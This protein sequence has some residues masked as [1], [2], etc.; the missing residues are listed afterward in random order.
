MIHPEEAE[1][2][3]HMQPRKAQCSLERDHSGAGYTW[4]SRPRLL[5][6]SQSRNHW[7]GAKV[8]TTTR[9]R[10]EAEWSLRSRSRCSADALEV[11]S[12]PSRV[13]SSSF[14]F[15]IPDRR[16]AHYRPYGP[17]IWL[18]PH[19][20]E[21]TPNHPLTPPPRVSF[22]VLTG[23]SDEACGVIVTIRDPTVSRNVAPAPVLN[24]L[25]LKCS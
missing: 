4:V 15:F 19:D 24:Q 10:V 5:N 7:L 20:W 23:C 12:W 18:N 16:H 8:E 11:T 14:Y 2:P 25:D 17:I 1:R 3:T 6:P 21:G 9:V 13:L 22:L